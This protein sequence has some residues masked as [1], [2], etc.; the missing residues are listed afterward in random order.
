MKYTI[1]KQDNAVY[2][3]STSTTDCNLSE[4]PSNI[5]AAHYFDD[6]EKGTVEFND[7]TKNLETHTLIEFETAINCQINTF[8]QKITEAKTARRQ[9]FSTNSEEISNE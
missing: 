5:H 6:T 2:V 4:I 9:A 1:I 8:E 3:G 7:G